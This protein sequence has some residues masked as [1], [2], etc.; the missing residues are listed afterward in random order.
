[1]AENMIHGD[2]E[3]ITMAKPH[4][5]ELRERV[6]SRVESGHT[7]TSTA[8]HFNVSI[9]FVNDMMKLKRETGK[10]VPRHNPGNTGNGK[11]EPYKAWI[12]ARVDEKSDITLGE[13][14]LELLETFDLR[15]SCPAVSRVLHEGGL[16]HKKRPST[17]VNRA[18]LT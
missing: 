2:Q 15:A 9:K 3:D 11:L 1:M 14:C 6:V 10:L 7:H 4:P 16:S 5:I 13:L 18:A 12:R 17:R 8:A